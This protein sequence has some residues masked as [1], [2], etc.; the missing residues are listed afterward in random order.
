MRILKFGGKSLGD[1]TKVFN[2]CKYIKSIYKKEKELIIVVS[3]QGKTTDSLLSLAKDYLGEETNKRELDVLLSTGETISSALFAMALTKENIPAKSFQAFQL[4]I[5]TFGDFGDSKIAYINKQP[6]LDCLKNGIVA[7]VSG[8]QGINK[9]SEI[10]TLGRG[11]SDTTTACLGAVFDTNIEIYSDFNGI[12][13]GDPR[14]LN[15]KKLKSI[16]YDSLETLSKHG[17]K[18]MHD[19]AT[20]IAQN[21]NIKIF[22]KSSEKPKLSGTEICSVEKD[23]VSI[24]MLENLC[25][26]TIVF[27]N[28][29]KLKFI[30]K[31][32]ISVINNYIFY[33]LTTNNDKI[34]FYVSEK[35]KNEILYKIS[36]NLKLIK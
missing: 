16:D 23:L 14:K 27:T 31:N 1:K 30:L 28:P 35:N 33:N 29:A 7:I 12:F 36:K 34:I 22:A 19:R 20:K 17:A 32:V 10:T 11:G 25:E 4:G 13:S 8:F 18:V 2:I 9:N 3:A 15:Y 6:I 5:T 24:S 21:F 26:I